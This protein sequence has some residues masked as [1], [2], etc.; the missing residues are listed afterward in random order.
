MMDLRTRQWDPEL[1]RHFKVPE[2]CLPRIV[3]SAEAV[4]T[5]D[6]GSVLDGVPI[7]G[8]VGDQQSACVGQMLFEPG[9]VK[10][11]YGT[12]PR[13]DSSPTVPHFNAHCNPNPFQVPVPL[14]S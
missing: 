6:C 13:V 10:N 8:L 3:T 4:G 14:C 1:M 11:T 5:L 9:M 12:Y 2:S 7:T